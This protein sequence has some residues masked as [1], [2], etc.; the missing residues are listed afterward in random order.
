MGCTISEALRH[1]IRNSGQT[2]YA[3]AK[4]TGLEAASI[5]RF[6]A[7]RQS[8]RLDMADRLA[9]HLGMELKQTK[10]RG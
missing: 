10:K 9:R 4:E 1:T 6:M 7:G 8:L 3:I 2:I 5:R